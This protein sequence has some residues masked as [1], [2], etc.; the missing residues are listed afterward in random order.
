MNG[1]GLVFVIH[2]YFSRH[3][4]DADNNATAK[5]V[6][7]AR[8]LVQFPNPTTPQQ[9]PASEESIEHYE[10]LD[11][12]GQY[13]ATVTIQSLYVISPPQPTSNTLIS[14]THPDHS[15]MSGPTIQDAV[16]SPLS[17]NNWSGLLSF[18]NDVDADN[19]PNWEDHLPLLSFNEP[20][21]PEALFSQLPS[22]LRQPQ[23]SPVPVGTTPSSFTS[24]ASR[25]TVV[26]SELTNRELLPLSLQDTT[27]AVTQV[28]VEIYFSGPNH[29]TSAGIVVRTTKIN[30]NSSYIITHTESSPSI[31]SSFTFISCSVH[32]CSA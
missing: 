11:T 31:K 10:T 16:S 21:Q 15:V 12:T 28:L 32:K 26:P 4:F 7:L 27:S 30:F 13:Q 29:Y 18:L 3:R 5:D 1:F 2:W 6:R 25:G 8:A 20:I 14:P 17:L 23:W 19:S 9:G 22:Q 24:K